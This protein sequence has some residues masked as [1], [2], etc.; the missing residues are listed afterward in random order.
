[1]YRSVIIL[2][3]VGL[4][5]FSDLCRPDPSIYKHYSSRVD[6]VSAQK[7]FA[8]LYISILCL[9]PSWPGR[10]RRDIV[11][12]RPSILDQDPVI[13]RNPQDTENTLQKS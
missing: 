11:N 1:M 10:R 13:G 2:S 8:A 7:F 6:L 3:S 5:G 12:S 9:V 4:G